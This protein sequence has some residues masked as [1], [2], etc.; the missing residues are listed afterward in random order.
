[1]QT[2]ELE[3]LTRAVLGRTPQLALY[4]RQWLDAS[5]ADDAV[6]EALTALLTQRPAPA[7]PVA[8]MFRAVRNAAIDQA[9]AAAR[10]KRRERTVAAQRVELFDARPDSPIDARRAEQA[11]GHLPIELSEVIVLR[12]WGEMGFAQIAQLMHL[13]VSTVHERYVR[14]LQ[15][16][17]R[18]LEQPCN[19]RT[20]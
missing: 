16:M 5:A 14:A 11:L 17:R 10:R 4:A 9:R 15:D 13:S 12:I 2:G 3:R 7:D 20:I 6:Q 1:M 19:T 8:W 18:Q